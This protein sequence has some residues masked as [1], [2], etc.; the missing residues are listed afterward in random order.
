MIVTELKGRSQVFTL[1]GGNT[2]RILA[3]E[4]KKIAD[5]SISDELKIAES[6]GLVLLTKDSK[7]PTTKNRRVNTD[8]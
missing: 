1:Q 3:R 8:G 5:K 4:S 7:V 2:L 6:M